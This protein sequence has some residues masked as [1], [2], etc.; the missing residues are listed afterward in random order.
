MAI[1]QWMTQW[2]D[3]SEAHQTKQFFPSHKPGISRDLLR[4][5][6][7]KLGRLVRIIT[8]HNNL[9]YHMSLKIPGHENS[10]RFCGL[11]FLVFSSALTLGT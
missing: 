5:S 2:N 8:G 9:N 7:T 4:M 11:F 3:Y 6:K 10:C 1:D